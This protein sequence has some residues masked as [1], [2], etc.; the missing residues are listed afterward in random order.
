[1]IKN[2]LRAA[3]F[4]NEISCLSC[5]NNNKTSVKR[6]EMC[7]TFVFDAVCLLD[8]ALVHVVCITLSPLRVLHCYMYVLTLS[9]RGS[10]LDVRI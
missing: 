1:M 9:A 10:T 3:G 2:P 7:G 8:N 6:R 5:F 4:H